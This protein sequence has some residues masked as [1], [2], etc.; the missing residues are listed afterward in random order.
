M[1]HKTES[2]QCKPTKAGGTVYFDDY[3]GCFS[4]INFGFLEGGDDVV[5]RFH[6]LDDKEGA[7]KLFDALLAVQSVS[8]EKYYWGG[9]MMTNPPVLKEKHVAPVSDL[10]KKHIIAEKDLIRSYLLT[11]LKK[12]VDGMNIALYT[13]VDTYDEENQSNDL[14]F[15]KKFASIQEHIGEIAH[16]IRERSLMEKPPIGLDEFILSKEIHGD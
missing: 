5:D 8:R 2:L 13:Y 3:S 12:F 7:Q 1:F 14:W 16:I 11:A 9:R 10:T 4:V 15:E 6:L